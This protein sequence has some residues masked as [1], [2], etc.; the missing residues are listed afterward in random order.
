MR[1]LD[2]WRL[3]NRNMSGAQLSDE[4]AQS[5]TLALQQFAE[6]KDESILRDIFTIFDRNRD[7]K[8]TKSELKTVMNAIASMTDEEVDGMLEE[9]DKNNDGMIDIREFAEV[10]SK[11]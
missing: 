7:G 10:L 4:E 6:T 11:S 2:A 8:I 5:L 9:A 1:L 3:A